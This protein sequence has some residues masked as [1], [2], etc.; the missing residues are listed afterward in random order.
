MS[1]KIPLQ[2]IPNQQLRVVLDNQACIIHL[3]TRNDRLFLDLTV[4]ENVVITGVLCVVDRNILQY[5]TTYFSGE[6]LFR[7]TSEA[8]TI[9]HWSG[10]GTTYE[11]FYSG[12]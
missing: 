1:V 4:G 9:P 12:V 3:Y 7:D 5:P 8:D 6:L 10:L 2:A 11:L